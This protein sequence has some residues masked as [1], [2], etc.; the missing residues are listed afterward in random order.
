[1]EAPVGTILVRGGS[2]MRG[3]EGE[4]IVNR[5]VQNKRVSISAF[6]MH[7]TEVTNEQYRKFLNVL[8]ERLKNPPAPASSA[9]LN[10]NIPVGEEGVKD[11]LDELLT[12]DFI[13][14]LYPDTTVWRN[15][16]SNSMADIYLEKYFESP[17]YDNYPVVGVTWESARHYA[18]WQTKYLNEYREKK[19][20]PPYPSFSLPSAAQWEYAARGGKELAKYPWG[21]P[22][23]RDHE[24][25]LRA[26]FKAGKGN[27]S[28]EGQPYTYTSP[29]DAFPP[30]D[31]GLYDMAGNVA[32][33]TLD[34][35]NPAA[36]SRTWDLDPLYLDDEQPLKIIK[37]GSWK[38]IPKFLQTGSID[39][40]HKDKARSDIGF[41][42]I[43]PFIGPQ[44][45]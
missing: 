44:E 2:F 41:R 31:F 25:K 32:E 6:F 40:E 5:N 17:A 35:Y 45:E 13:K 34:A 27:Y 38:S 14:T 11:K 21:G 9:N 28:E 15:D 19:G 3:A 10:S 24:G 4:D 43:L 30:N 12:E 26:N 22:Y 23:L 16:F 42:L 7:E 36:I 37:G 1:M 18:A 39:Y 33:W 20:L 8:S 29:V